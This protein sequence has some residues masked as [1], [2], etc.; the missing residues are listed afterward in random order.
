[1]TTAVYINLS[2]I[3]MAGQLVLKIQILYILIEFKQKIIMLK[4]AAHFL[5][6]IFIILSY[7]TVILQIRFQILE[8]H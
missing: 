5:L 4:Q 8:E 3:V 1:M 6:I 7:K 2:N